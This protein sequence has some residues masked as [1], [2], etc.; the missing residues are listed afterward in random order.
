MLANISKYAKLLTTV[1]GAV[2]MVANEVLPIVPASAQHW[3]TGVIAVLTIVARDVTEILGGTSN[4][5][6]KAPAPPA[7]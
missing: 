1:I 3:V 7:A 4:V 5:S 2:L 6:A